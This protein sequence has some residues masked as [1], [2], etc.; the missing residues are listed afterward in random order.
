MD[1]GMCDPVA[2]FVESLLTEV[3]N[4]IASLMIARIIGD[5]GDASIN[6]HLC[7]R[8]EFLSAGEQS[9]CWNSSV[10]KRTI[11]GSAVE[12]RWFGGKILAAEIG[13]EHV[14]YER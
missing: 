13:E 6:R 1:N 5:A 3:Q 11:V 14:F 4:G 8:L 12:R 9:A 7:G 2:H 10:D